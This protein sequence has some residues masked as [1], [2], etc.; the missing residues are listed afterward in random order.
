MLRVLRSR[1]GKEKDEEEA[2]KIKNSCTPT[3]KP[4]KRK[5]ETPKPTEESSQSLKKTST[6]STASPKRKRDEIE[7][8]ENK[9]L[10]R[11]FSE[12]ALQESKDWDEF[13][14]YGGEEEDFENDIIFDQDGRQHVLLGETDSESDDEDAAKNDEV[15]ALA[16]QALEGY[17]AFDPFLFMK[18]LPEKSMLEENYP[19]VLPPLIV[20]AFEPIKK[21]KREMNKK[22]VQE[23]TSLK[24][25]Q[26]L[27]Y[28][29]HK[30][31]TLVLDLDETLVHS[32]MEPI[33]NPDF[34][35]TVHAC[36]TSSTVYVKSRPYL[37]QF[38]A[39][40]QRHFEI[41]VF[42]ASHKAYAA[43]LLDHIDPENIFFDHR[44]Y[45][46]ACSNVDGLY[47][48]DLDRLGRDLSKTTII[49]NTLYV[50]GYQPD[51]AIPIESWFDDDSDTA[52]LDLLP[53]L[54]HLRNADD[55]R[56]L[57]RNTF[58]IRQKIDQASSTSSGLASS[59]YSDDEDDI[60]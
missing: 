22:N 48:K 11:S 41:V 38:L 55:V 23:D 39:A 60:F 7:K 3:K 34:V 12:D 16:T 20:P 33:V 9:I 43:T 8:K 50:F 36:G 57:L 15:E 5:I 54:D 17:E 49:D 24:I 58:Q 27:K 32:Q 44:L 46:E 14:L 40:V 31:H 42:T 47:L 56:P 18:Q 28:V 21:K 6:P 2:K 29:E 10:H 51:N 37:K 30:T 25:Q 1:V 59:Y 19:P 13:A 26:N 52:L 4:T 53:F 35:F 45:R